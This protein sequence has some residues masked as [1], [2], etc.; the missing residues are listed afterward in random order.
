VPSV[1][2]KKKSA[3]KSLEG[4]LAKAQKEIAELKKQKVVI[5][6]VVED[7]ADT[8]TKDKL[9]GL[10]KNAKNLRNCVGAPFEKLLEDVNAEIRA[11]EVQVT[12]GKP[13][14]EQ[15]KIVQSKLARERKDEDAIQETIEVDT[16]AL[17][18][19]SKQLD[20]S[21]EKLEE[22]QLRI[23]EL[24]AQANDL[25]VKMAGTEVNEGMGAAKAPG[26]VVSAE[27]VGEAFLQ[28]GMDADNVEKVKAV[29]Q[30]AGF[31]IFLPNSSSPP[32]P[33]LG[34]VKGDKGEGG[35]SVTVAA[36]GPIVDAD[37]DLAME[38]DDL[39]AEGAVD[40]TAEKKE[41]WFTVA[42]KRKTVAQ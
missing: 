28:Q 2:T 15:S 20:R 3:K 42:K 40:D 30:H 19:L 11:L 36:K 23:Q 21:R 7:D 33:P 4:Q 1:S 25:N 10:R 38:W 27:A 14:L 5:E 6:P 16:L 8:T 39:V 17:A 24:T 29:L 32:S 22:K 31:R 18:E 12:Q 9:E 34:A 41:K 13:L 26:G 37:G 35:E